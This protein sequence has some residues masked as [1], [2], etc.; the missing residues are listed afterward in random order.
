MSDGVEITVVENNTTVDVSENI[1]EVNITPTET[2]IEVRGI[3]IA[4]SNATGISVS[5]AGDSWLTGLANNVQTSLDQLAE[6]PWRF[7]AGGS[8]GLLGSRDRFYFETNNGVSVN[9]LDTG[10]SA[11]EISR[12]L[13]A[14]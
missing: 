8:N 6:N 1:T 5:H 10:R 7:R 11:T 9:A 12:T 4:T 14:L 13:Q 2:T 3:S